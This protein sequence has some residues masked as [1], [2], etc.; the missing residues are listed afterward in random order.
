MHIMFTFCI[1]STLSILILIDL[2][3]SFRLGLPPNEANETKKDLQD[4]RNYLKADYKVHVT[5]NSTVADHCSTF[6]LSQTDDI[7][8]QTQC[9]HDHID[10]CDRCELIKVTLTKI[11]GYVERYQRDESIRDRFLHRVQHQIQCINE[12]KSHLIRTVHQDQA[13]VDVLNQLD[14]ESILLHVDW[15]MKWLPVKYREST[16]VL[17]LVPIV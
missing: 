2:P 11:C 9:N 16:V 14:H 8:W 15:A 7:Y 13:R 1:R 10:K 12:W 4:C 3:F 6:S 5:S 17:K